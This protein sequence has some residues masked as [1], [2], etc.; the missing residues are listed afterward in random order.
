MPRNPHA[1]HAVVMNKKTTNPAMPIATTTPIIF[2]QNPAPSP[3]T[4]LLSSAARFR[5]KPSVGIASS[6]PDEE[7]SSS[8]RDEL[9]YWKAAGGGQSSAGCRFFRRHLGRGSIVG[10]VDRRRSAHSSEIGRGVNGRRRDRGGQNERK[11]AAYANR[12]GRPHQQ[13]Q[14]TAV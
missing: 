7:P 5:P 1:Y 4:A 2:S 3:S 9:T 6:A 14:R 8:A 10:G 11:H 13:R 12:P